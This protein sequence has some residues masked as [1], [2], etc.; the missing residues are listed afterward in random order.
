MKLLFASNDEIALSVLDELKPDAVLTTLSNPTGR[1]KRLNPVKVW[2]L[3]NNKKCFEVEHLLSSER[4]EIAT[5]G[6]DTLLS[7]S[8]SK[9]FGPKF[10]SIFKNGAY[11]IHPSP[12]P[13]LRGPSPIQNAILEGWSETEVV[14]QTLSLK[15]DEGDI[16]N[17]IS[18]P[19]DE[20]D[21]YISLSKRVSECAKLL[22]SSFSSS[23]SEGERKKQTGEA[24]YTRLFT[25]EDGRV[26]FEEGELTERKI[27][28]FSVFPKVYAF[29]KDKSVVFTSS[30]FEKAE[31]KEKCGKVVSFSK[32]KGFKIAFKDGY[33]YLSRLC[34]QAKTECDAVS[35]N[36]GYKNFVGSTLT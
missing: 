5:Y 14:L 9:I 18:V 35:F 22:A 16:I 8:F 13:L 26:N 27:R 21:D 20:R 17:R 4:E 12:L 30:T 29:W 15:M 25:K 32:D 24:T 6:F 11:N 7:F 19:I 34:L 2:A 3:E 36:N 28:A 1:K 23:I 31:V 10:L 33:L